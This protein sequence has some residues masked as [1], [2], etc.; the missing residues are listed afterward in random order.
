[1]ES[2]ESELAERVRKR[3]R[4]N[5]KM[6]AKYAHTLYILFICCVDL[7]FLLRSFKFLLHG[8]VVLWDRLLGYVYA[9]AF[10]GM[11]GHVQV[12]LCVG[13]NLLC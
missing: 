12:R 3:L 7:A 5:N 11:Y 4:N 10:G 6:N 1:M 8:D 13:I 9:F 2:R